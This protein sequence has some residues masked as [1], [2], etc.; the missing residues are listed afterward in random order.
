MALPDDHSIFPV[1]TEL[2]AC[3]C[4]ELGQEASPCFCGVITAGMEVPVDESCESCAVGYVRLDSAFPSTVRF[5]EPDQDA[6][7]RAV[8][9]FAV[10]VGVQRCVPMGDDMGNPPTSEELAEYARQIFADMAVIRRAIRCCLVDS[11]FE[12]IEYVL[13]SYS[14]LSADSGAGGG[15]WTLT[16]RERF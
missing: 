3:L 11:K 5:P 6:T 10:T 4:A 15:E 7:C 1:L 8:M 9:A 12:D 2:A 16:I 14:Q 13:G